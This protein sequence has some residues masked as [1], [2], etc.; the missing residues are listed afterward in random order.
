MSNP[1]RITYDNSTPKLSVSLSTN[2]TNNQ[3]S[4]HDHPKFKWGTNFLGCEARKTQKK[5]PYSY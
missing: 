2:I 5:T 4:E 3:R 1:A